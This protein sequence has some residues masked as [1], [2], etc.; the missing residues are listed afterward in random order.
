M[1]TKLYVLYDQKTEGYNLPFYSHNDAHAMRM[2]FEAMKDSESSISKYPM[3]FHLFCIGEYDGNEGR[4][5]AREVNENL[6]SVINIYN[7]IKRE[8]KR[9]NEQLNITQEKDEISDEA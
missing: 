5:K 6:G 3:D 1:K 4:I 7:S 8:L 9:T 2:V